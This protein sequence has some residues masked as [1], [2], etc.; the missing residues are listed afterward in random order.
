MTVQI[1]SYLLKTKFLI[2]IL[3]GI[4]GTA[5]ITAMIISVQEHHVETVEVDI[6]PGSGSP[7]HQKNVSPEI[8]KVVIG[9]NNTVRW[10]NID[11]TSHTLSPNHSSEGFP[12][13]IGL[14]RSGESQEFTFEI[15]GVYDYHGEPGPWI[16]GTVIVEEKTDWWK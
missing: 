7:E 4:L 16:V 15:P 11:D 12:D 9:V 1:A 10:N 8:V 6:L 14:L 3:T 2:Y 13:S 5:S